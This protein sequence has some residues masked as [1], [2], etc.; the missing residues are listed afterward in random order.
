MWDGECEEVFRKLKEI[1]TSTPPILAYANFSKP[2][3][4]YTDVCTLGLGAI[5]YQNQDMVDCV[6]GYAN[7]SLSKTEHKYPA[8]N[9]EFWALK[10]AVTDQFHEYLYGNTFVI[11][12]YNNQLAY[13]LN[14]AKLDATG[15]CW[16]ASLANFNLALSYQSEK[17]NVDADA[18]SHIPRGR[19]NQHIEAYSVHVLISQVVQDTTLIKAYSCNIQV[20][21]TLDMQDPKV[22][23]LVDWITAQSKDSVIREIKYLISKNKLKGLRCI[24]GT[25]RL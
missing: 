12:M 13:V 24:H 17:M 22:M 20:T 8:H 15:H 5:L 21:E 3:E 1:C 18:L 25:H 6:I 2:F 10:W 19:H 9:F 14:S 23:S 11:Y 7:R 4:L 16:V